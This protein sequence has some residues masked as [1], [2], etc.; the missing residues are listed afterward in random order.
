MMTLPTMLVAIEV[1]MVLSKASCSSISP[2]MLLM[3]GDGGPQTGHALHNL[4]IVPAVEG[5][6]GVMLMLH[7]SIHAYAALDLQAKGLLPDSAH[8]PEC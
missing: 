4:V 5:A 6:A 7:Q 8:S 1:M 2:S 3:M